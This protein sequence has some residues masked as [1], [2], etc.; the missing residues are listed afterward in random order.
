MTTLL[1][2]TGST[3]VTFDDAVLIAERCFG[4]LGLK[5]I[6]LWKQYNRDYFSDALDVTPVLYV[7]VSP[8]GHWVGCFCAGRNIYLM[9]PSEERSWAFVR[10]VLL[11]EM[12]H[13]HLA[14]TGNNSQHACEPWCA[15]IMRI[16]RCLGVNIWAGKYTVKKVNGKSVRANQER[17]ASMNGRALNQKQISQWPH[18]IGIAPP[19]TSNYK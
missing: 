8:Y 7:P 17:P 13:Q 2:T 11:H 15:E 9:F 12:V 1:A 5:T 10:G 18:S 14:Q 19:D 16:S 4:D 6:F 3:A